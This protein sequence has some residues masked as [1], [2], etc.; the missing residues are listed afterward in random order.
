MLDSVFMDVQATT[1]RLLNSPFLHPFKFYSQ[2]DM[3]S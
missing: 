3:F 1:A 2:M